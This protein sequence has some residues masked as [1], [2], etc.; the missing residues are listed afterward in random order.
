MT[1]WHIVVVV[2]LGNQ[3]DRGPVLKVVNRVVCDE[4][5][6]VSPV[7]AVHLNGV[8]QCISKEEHFHL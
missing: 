2:V 5:L 3:A 7:E 8:L 6:C 4:L 1:N